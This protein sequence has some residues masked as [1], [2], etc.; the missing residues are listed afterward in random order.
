MKATWYQTL[1]AQRQGLGVAFFYYESL[2]DESPEPV[3]Q[4]QSGFLSLFPATA[5]RYSASVSVEDRIPDE[6]SDEIR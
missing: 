4:R 6:I 2:W 1:A 3:A 5:V